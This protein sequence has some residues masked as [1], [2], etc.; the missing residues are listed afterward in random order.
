MVKKT[1]SEKNGLRKGTWT[2]E[3]DKK[4]I[5]YVTRY[6]HW[7]WNLLP[8]FAGLERCGKSCRLRWL[9]YLRPN[10]KRG[11]YTK[12]ED[13]TIIKLLQSLGNRWS[14]IAAQLPGRTDNEIKN[15]WHTNLKKRYQLL[16][17][18]VSHS[19]D[20]SPH[21]QGPNPNNNIAPTS[22]FIDSCTTATST[23]TSSSQ[24]SV[25]TATKENF[26]ETISGD[27][28]FSFVDAYQLEPVN[29]SFF[30]EPYMV[31][32]SCLPSDILV[33]EPDYFSPVS[34]IELWNHSNIYYA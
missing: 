15:Y 34:D 10:I 14:A 13:D 30:L 7:N 4:L 31:D 33:P 8:K 32:I 25:T 23:S 12:E 5:A 1:N 24:L 6:G 18:Q 17:P 26:L 16:K 9:N 21:E 3:E 27:D 22:Q 20:Q 29:E 2:P 19:K 11:N 28:D